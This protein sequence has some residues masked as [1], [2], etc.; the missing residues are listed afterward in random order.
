M[1]STELE[2]EEVE[3]RD[4]FPR[5]SSVANPQVSVL[6]NWNQPETWD[7]RPKKESEELLEVSVSLTATGSHKTEHISTTRW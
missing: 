5:V 6:I 1:L 4:L 7:Q 2:S 3:E